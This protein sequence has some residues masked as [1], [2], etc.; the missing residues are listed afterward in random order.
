MIRAVPDDD[1]RVDHRDDQDHDEDHDRGLAFDLPRI[2]GRRRALQVLAG[3]GLATLVAAC[4]SGGSDDSGSGSAD[5]DAAADTTTSGNS[6][7]NTSEAIPEETA[8]PYPGDGSNGPNVLE[9]S[10][11]VRSD[12][13]SSFAGSQG[14]AEGVPLTINL[15]V[16]DVSGSGGGGPRPGA[17]VYVWH[18]D[19]DG[20]YSLYTVADQNYLR[21]VQET[22]DDG[23]VTFTSIFPG[24]YPG[25]WPH[26]HFEVYESLDAATGGGTKLA[27]SQLA[28]PEE[29]CREAYGAD[30]YDASAGNLDGVSLDGD[31]VF[32]DGWSLE[33]ATV[34]GSPSGGYTAT[35]NVPV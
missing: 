29:T 19:K 9:E 26:V 30:G 16:L 14:T 31:M 22:A 33:M 3:G 17:A 21:G 18:C 2:L 6:G 13:R 34:T 35:L 11:V 12:I 20:G 28:L 5:A 4:G 10:G 8:G 23:T 25:R 32:S 1:H 24:C 7:E 15:T 27:T